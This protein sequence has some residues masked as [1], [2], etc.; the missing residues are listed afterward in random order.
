V[1]SRSAGSAWLLRAVLAILVTAVVAG[2][3]LR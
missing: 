2:A 1:N 3:I